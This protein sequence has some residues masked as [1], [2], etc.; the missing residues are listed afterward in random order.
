[1]IGN[2]RIFGEIFY[3]LDVFFFP[4]VERSAS[5]T[6]CCFAVLPYING[7]TE[8]LTRTL[9]NHDIRETNRPLHTLQHFPSPKYS[10]PTEK[11]T[12]V[13]K[14]IPCGNCS[15]SCIGETSRSLLIK[16]WS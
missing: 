14:T 15:C 12:N 4:L 5:F 16:F 7:V 6:V 1:M 13:V 11:E 8:M 9:Q 2:A 3:A 10:V